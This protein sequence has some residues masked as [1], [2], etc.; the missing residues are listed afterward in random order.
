MKMVLFSSVI[1]LDI[2]IKLRVALFTLVKFL[3]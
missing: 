1:L 3:K 2:T